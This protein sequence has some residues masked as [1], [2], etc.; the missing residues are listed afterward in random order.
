MQSLAAPRIRTH[1]REPGRLPSGLK[2]SS[3]QSKPLRFIFPIALGSFGPT[4]RK[5]P[6][7]LQFAILPY[8]EVIETQLLLSA[9]AFI[10]C[11]RCSIRI[12]DYLGLRESIPIL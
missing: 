1:P 9:R 10:S 2:A 6:E 12:V 5:I 4:F 11:A 8:A 7:H 3:N